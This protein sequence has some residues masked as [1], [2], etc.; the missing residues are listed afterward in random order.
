[1]TWAPF[2]YQ[3][4]LVDEKERDIIDEQAKYVKEKLNNGQNFHA[5]LEFLRT[6]NLILDITDGVDFYNV[7]TKWDQSSKNKINSGI[8]RN[9]S[10]SRYL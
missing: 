10:F 5:T 1:M 2:L 9:I 6:Q 8:M 4:S 3:M 7:L